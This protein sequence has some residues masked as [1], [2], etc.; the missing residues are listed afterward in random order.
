MSKIEEMSSYLPLFLTELR[1]MKEILLSEAPEI[2][3]QQHLIFDTLDQFFISTATW[4]LNRWEHKLNVERI[5]NDTIENRRARCLNKTSNIPPVTYRSLERAVNRFLKNPSA[6]IRLVP[7][8]YQLNVDMNMDDMQYIDMIV[9]V[10]ESMKPA[11]LVY[12][13]RAALNNSIK[14]Q[15]EVIINFRRYRRVRE[16]RVGLSVTR[17]NNEVILR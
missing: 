1:E 2:E 14:I 9:E 13:L 5:A 8:D 11:H 6:F 10:L 17:D 3:N 15:N 16:M 7:E 12:T 4:S